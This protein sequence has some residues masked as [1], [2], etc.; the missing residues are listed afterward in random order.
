[1]FRATLTHHQEAHLY[2]NTLQPIGCSNYCLYIHLCVLYIVT[3]V[4][5]I[6]DDGMA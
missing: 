1:M 4:P 6:G 3:T 2:L 5:H